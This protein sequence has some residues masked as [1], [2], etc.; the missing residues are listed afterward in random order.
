MSK[1]KD[2]IIIYYKEYYQD[3][4]TRITEVIKTSQNQKIIEYKKG[5][6][7][8]DLIKETEGLNETAEKIK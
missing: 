6:R 1:I 4:I 3:I 8:G 7:I 5:G 2:N